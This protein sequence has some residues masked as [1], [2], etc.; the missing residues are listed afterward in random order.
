MAHK[1]RRRKRK[2]LRPKWPQKLAC[3][4]RLTRKLKIVSFWSGIPRLAGGTVLAIATLVA[5][6]PWLSVQRDDSLDQSSPYATMFVIS[7]SGYIHATD[8]NAECVISFEGSTQNVR[9]MHVSNEK[10]GFAK[11]AER[12]THNKPVTLPCFKSMGMMSRGLYGVGL[13][14]P[15]FRKVSLGIKIDFAFPYINWKWTRQHKTFNFEGII[16]DDNTWHWKYLG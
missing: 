16:G 3:L 5:I 2:R 4:S 13:E 7:N 15:T 11:F 6:Y 9:N 8:V 12:L 1:R 14:K 10:F